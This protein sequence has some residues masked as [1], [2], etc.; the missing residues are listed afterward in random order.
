MVLRCLQA[1]EP[2]CALL[3]YSGEAFVSLTLVKIGGVRCVESTDYPGG[4][5][6]RE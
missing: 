1:R 6:R 4:Q 5:G 3:L 2:T